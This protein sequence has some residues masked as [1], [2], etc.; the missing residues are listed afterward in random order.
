MPF[1]NEEAFEILAVYFECLQSGVI[2]SR[3]N[4]ARFPDFILTT[5]FVTRHCRIR[6]LKGVW[7]I[8][9]GY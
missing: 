9:I 8:A 6:I 7:I 2:A 5:V 4:A 1:T 3:V